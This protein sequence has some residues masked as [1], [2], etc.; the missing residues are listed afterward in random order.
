VVVQV[1]EA[2]EEILAAVEQVIQVVAVEDQDT[3]QQEAVLAVQE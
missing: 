3:Q 1:V 2:T